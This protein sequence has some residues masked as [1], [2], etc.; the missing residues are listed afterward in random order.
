M[1]NNKSYSDYIDAGSCIW[2]YCKY[3]N[4]RDAAVSV[5]Y[6]RKYCMDVFFEL[7]DKNFE[8]ICW[9]RERVWKSLFSQ[10]GYTYIHCYFRVNY[11]C[12]AVCYF[13]CF[14]Y[15]LCGQRYCASQLNGVVIAG[16]HSRNRDIGDGMRY[17]H[18]RIDD[19]VPGFGSTGFIWHA[20]MDVRKCSHISSFFFAG[21][22]GRIVDVESCSTDYRSFSLC[23]YRTRDFF[24]AIFNDKYGY[25]SCDTFY[26]NCNIQQSRE[27]LYGYG[28]MKEAI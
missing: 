7:P 28:L 20:V 25:I 22:M 18:I 15:L 9:K 27:E 16:P 4:R 11:F 12:S 8:Y 21:E 14:R 13:S 1:D 26:R 19:K 23:L 6:G 5:L 2:E 3:L 10:T 17:Y 24:C